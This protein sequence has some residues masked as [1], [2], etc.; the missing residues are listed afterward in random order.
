MNGAAE[1]TRPCIA[2]CR[3]NN[4]RL[5][6][7]RREAQAK[8]TQ[9]KN[10]LFELCSHNFVQLVLMKKM[11]KKMSKVFARRCEKQ[12]KASKFQDAID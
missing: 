7:H 4:I 11:A 1:R 2:A 3:H 12:S 10:P 8:Q 5:R 6:D 9:A